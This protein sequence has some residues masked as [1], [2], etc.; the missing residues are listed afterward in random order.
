MNP[1]QREWLKPALTDLLDLIGKRQKGETPATGAAEPSG[2]DEE[3]APAP[4]AAKQGEG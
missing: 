1:F 4:D 3:P 2:A